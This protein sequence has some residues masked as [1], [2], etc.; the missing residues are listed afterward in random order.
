MC[1]P[2]SDDESGLTSTEHQLRTTKETAMIA[3]L[4]FQSEINYRADRIKAG[5]TG[6]PVRPRRH[7]LVRRHRKSATTTA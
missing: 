1:G 3:E 6:T 2:T 5:V 4:S 7:S